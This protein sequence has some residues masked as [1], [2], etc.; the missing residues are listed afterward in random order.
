M[1]EDAF[2][3]EWL[4]SNLADFGLGL[5]LQGDLGG[6]GLGLVSGRGNNNAGAIGADEGDD[7]EDE[8]DAEV[9]R[10]DERDRI[11]S[12]SHHGLP[13]ASTSRAGG[14]R[15]PTLTRAVSPKRVRMDIDSDDYDAV[16]GP[17]T[18]PISSPRKPLESEQPRKKRKVSKKSKEKSLDPDAPPKPRDIKEVWPDFEKGTVLNFTKMLNYKVEKKPRTGYYPPLEGISTSFRQFRF[19][20]SLNPPS[21]EEG[22]PIIQA[23]KPS[24]R[25][26]S[27]AFD[28]KRISA[29]VANAIENEQTSS[30][31]VNDASK[32]TDAA[33]QRALKVR[34]RP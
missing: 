8:I 4:Q 15:S 7:Y 5:D 6:L 33:L 12:S 18:A 1:D 14:L 23:P 32:W 27:T 3:N 9:R 22:Q 25:I 28:L 29:P 30:D 19:L 17:A 26:R 21:D 2:A 34:P 13:V 24:R 11:A 10:E 16:E 31:I 20:V